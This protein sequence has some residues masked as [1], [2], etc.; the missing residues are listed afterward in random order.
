MKKRITNV[1]MWL[2]Y[3]L[4]LSFLIKFIK[5]SLPRLAN[6][7]ANGQFEPSFNPNIGAFIV[8]P[9]PPKTMSPASSSTHSSMEDAANQVMLDK[10]SSMQQEMAKRQELV[11]ASMEACLENVLNGL[12]DK[13][14][15]LTTNN[16]QQPP[17]QNLGSQPRPPHHHH[18]DPLFFHPQLHSF[19]GTDPQDWLFQAEQYFNLYQVAPIQRLELVAFSMKGN[20]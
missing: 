12:V 3:M 7:L 11:H 20:C 15:R 8:V 1:E 9:I 4:L 10:L 17:P 16:I 19:D 6:L 5:A 18:M 2:F 13:L 14:A